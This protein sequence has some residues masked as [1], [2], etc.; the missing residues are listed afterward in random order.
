MQELAEG[1]LCAEN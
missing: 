1:S